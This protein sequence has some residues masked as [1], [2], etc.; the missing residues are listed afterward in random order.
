ML[1]CH[2]ITLQL[3]FLVAKAAIALSLEICD[4]YKAVFTR[5]ICFNF[6]TASQAATS[7]RLTSGHMA[8]LQLAKIQST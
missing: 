1:G 6:K 8:D 3:D 5:K 7:N 2:S 4:Y